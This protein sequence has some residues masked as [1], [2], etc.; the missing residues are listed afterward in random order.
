MKRDGRERRRP[1]PGGVA[2]PAQ[3][4][5]AVEQGFDPR[6]AGG[7]GATGGASGGGPGGQQKVGGGGGFWQN[8]DGGM[9]IGERST[10]TPAA[11]TQVAV[12]VGQEGSK[13]SVVAAVGVMVVQRRRWIGMEPMMGAFKAVALKEPTGHR[14][15]W[16][17]MTRNQNGRNEGDEKGWPPP[18][19]AWMAAF[20]ARRQTTGISPAISGAT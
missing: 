3:R 7:G 15:C 8:D 19:R 11:G 18:F 4:D 13:R 9:D 5:D 1:A 16:A 17:K 20:A 12:A 6:R 2:S 10:S 14:T